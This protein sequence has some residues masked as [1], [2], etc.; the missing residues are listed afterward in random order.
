M[1][2]TVDEAA[3]ILGVTPEEVHEL[4]RKKLMPDPIP[5][6]LLEPVIKL[7]IDIMKSFQRKW[8]QDHDAGD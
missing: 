5:E 8:M 2:L 1:T 3:V 7:R 4:Q 6:D